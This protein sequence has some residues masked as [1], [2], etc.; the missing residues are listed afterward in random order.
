MI[1][2]NLIFIII[3]AC[4][5]YFDSQIFPFFKPPHLFCPSHLLDSLEYK[6]QRLTI[7]V[8][9]QI[10]ENNLSKSEWEIDINTGFEIF[11]PLKK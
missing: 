5:K 6:V 7:L 3:H 9:I 10:L 1:H 8:K 4:L 11:L 2:K